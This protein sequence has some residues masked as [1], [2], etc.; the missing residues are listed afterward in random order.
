MIKVGAVLGGR[1]RVVAP[2]G[3]GGMASVWRGEQLTTGLRVA[4]KSILG[5]MLDTPGA[6]VRFQSEARAVAQLRSAHVVRLI[7]FDVDAAHGPFLVMELLEG[8]SLGAR[9]HRGDRPGPQELRRIVAQLARGL[10]HA[11]AAGI[12]HRDLKPENVFLAREDGGAVVAKLVDFGVAKV[13]LGTQSG[14]TSPGMLVGTAAYMSPEQ[15]VGQ[16]ADLR[17]DLWALGV[18]VYECVVGQVPF[19]GDTLGNTLLSI[20][21]KP[22]PIPST[23]SPDVTPAFDAWFARACARDP[24][25]RFPSAAQMS[26][27]LDACGD[28]EAPTW[29]V[30]IPPSI[31]EVEASAVPPSSS[32]PAEDT[33]EM[34]HSTAYYV[35]TGSTTVGPV[36]RRRLLRSLEGGQIAAGALV[37]REG[38]PRWRA[39]ASVREW[40]RDGALF[41]TLLHD[42]AQGAHDAE[43]RPSSG[44]LVAGRASHEHEPLGPPSMP[45]PCAP[46][47]ALPPDDPGPDAAIFHVFDGVNTSG[48]FTGRV[49]CRGA[50]LRVISRKAM[51]WRKGWDSWRTVRDVVYEL[52]SLRLS[53]TGERPVVPGLRTLGPPTIPPV[54]APPTPPSER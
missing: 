7:D 4:I 25:A 45:P 5:E 22:L 41:S 42:P 28:L 37:W 30:R 26:A 48:P 53:E 23:V 29:S 36:T 1:Y 52:A 10:D 35:R 38:W 2:L 34:E 21:S 49:L 32:E 27:E 15:A 19:G 33:I 20:C 9:L 51:V 40:L 13:P 16:T 31:R 47:P 8:E 46:S 54:G 14:L 18:I 6:L 39:A 50:A 12:V 43:D 24:A 17:S 44:T 11:H 3:A